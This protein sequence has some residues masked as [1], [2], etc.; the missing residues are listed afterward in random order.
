MKISKIAEIQEA[1][2]PTISEQVVDVMAGM[3]IA[4][5]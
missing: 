3:S 4:D 1:D 5:S 2:D